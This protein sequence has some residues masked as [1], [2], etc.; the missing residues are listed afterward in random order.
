MKILFIAGWF[1]QGD[2][3]KG[4]FVKEHA[5]A[6]AG[7]HEVAVI[8]GEENTRQKEKFRFSFS[9]EDGLQILRF[10][11]REILFF[12]SYRRYVKGVLMAFEKFL[13]IDFKPDIIHA[14]VYFTG[15]PANIIRKE[16][17]IPYVITEHYS[18]FSRRSLR[19]SKI[20]QAIIGMGGAEYILPVSNALK[21]DIFAYGI[22]GRF[23]VVP[24]VV[25]DIFCYVPV[26]GNQAGIKQ[27]LCVAAMHPKKNIPNLINACRILYR[28]RRDFNV[29]IVGE[30]KKMAEYAE[31]VRQAS[32]DNVIQFPGSRSKKEIARMMQ[33]SD[34]FVLPSKHEPFGCVLAE[35]LACGLPVVATNVGGIPEVVDGNSGILV[36]SD[37]PQALSAAM[38]R[39]M[40]NP[41]IFDRKSISLNARKKYSYDTVAEQLDGIYKKVLQ[42]YHA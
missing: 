30:G 28:V 15:V 12:S 24:N 5:L 13:A 2:N 25:P 8:Y 38:N 27:I 41:G 4:I 33:E 3:Y 18:G 31:L 10:T 11:Y 35:A 21:E 14:N 1:P 16:Y 20:K 19:K 17:N 9:T 42:T 29:N 34:F 22:R 6:V 32:L 26:S 39:M 7:K 36:E 40:D 23:E 37:N